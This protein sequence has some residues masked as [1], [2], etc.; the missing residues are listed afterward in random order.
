MEFVDIAFVV[1]LKEEFDRLITTFPVIKDHVDGTQFWVQL[2]LGIGEYTAVAILQDSMGKSAAIRAADTLLARYKIGVM[3]VVGIA[4]G[5]SGDVAIGDVC[6]SGSIFDILENQ[7]ISDTSKGK[8]KIEYNTLPFKTDTLLSFSLKYVS[9]P[10]QMKNAFE[11]WQSEQYYNAAALV[12][13]EFIGRKDK[14]EKISIPQIHE[15]SV[16]CGSVSK[17]DIYKSNISNLDRKLLAIETESGGVFASAERNDVPAISIR[18]I[19]DYAD[20]NKNKLEEQTEGQARWIAAANAVTFVKLQL[21]NPQFHRFLDKRRDAFNGIKEASEKA[22]ALVELMPAALK[23]AKSE[24]HSQLAQLSPEYQGKPIGYRLPLP[25]VKYAASNA[26]VSP[27]LKNFDP[28]NVLEAVTTHKTVFI[29]TPK[30]YPDNSL[31]WII[32]S[33]LSLIEINDRQVIP[34]VIDGSAIRPPSGSLRKNA[35]LDIPALY[36]HDSCTLVFIVHN[37]D[38]SSRT[39]SEYLRTEMDLYKNSHFVLVGK[40]VEDINESTTLVLST[41]AEKFELCE[42]S[43]SELSSFFKRT[44]NLEDQQAGVLT[45]R[46]QSM[47][48]KFDLNAH[49]SY[50]A[51]LGNETLASLLKANRRAELLQIAVGGFLSFVV[52]GDKDDVVLSRTTRETFLKKFVYNTVFLKERFDEAALVTFVKQFAVEK[53]FAIDSLLFIRNFQDKGIIHFEGGFAKISLPFIESYL[54]AEELAARPNDA[55]QYFDVDDENF[56]YP[57]FDVFCE[58]N[59]SQDITNRIIEK[60][61]VALDRERGLEPKDHILLTNQIRPTYVVHPQKLKSIQNQLEKAV[62]DVIANRGNSS[63]KQQIIDVAEKVETEARQFQDVK[64]IEN[65]ALETSNSDNLGQLVKLWNVG[66]VLLGA[67]SEKLDRDPKR[68]L[69]RKIVE[70]SSLIIDRLLAS[71][72]RS[73]FDELKDQISSEESLRSLF[74]IEANDPILDHQKELVTAIVDAYE[75]S[76]LGY[77]MRL[78]LEQLGNLASQPV[79]RSSVSSVDSEDPMQ[80][81]IAKIWAAEIDASKEKNSL[82]SA[83][84]RLPTAQFLRVSLSTYFITRVFWNHWQPENRLALLD[85]AEESLKPLNREI[86]KG[87]LQRMITKGIDNAG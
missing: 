27:K 30:S 56:D 12:P 57:T 2:D 59:V 32:A 20:K 25:R 62:A 18:G 73:H 78:V 6:F 24:I 44:F 65:S 60:I 1:P 55:M 48:K 82:L 75:F 17:S 61:G 52:A 15:G 74:S 16:V 43:F 49:P 83:I 40:N 64:V 35:S 67:G 79:L 87:D 37:F 13:G 41:A 70:A 77:P 50:F 42:I 51:G 47:F 33:E 54:L 14:N 46:L 8:M 68:E 9:L 53:D 3:A 39:R 21:A 29:T 45:L 72:P 36:D 80:N 11:E 10:N 58:L 81:L 26:T 63:E 71:F 19:C 76:L 28:M 34:V 66:I 85:A 69:A 84:S 38:G 86:K 31:P 4:G 7:K 23:S 5:L 22:K